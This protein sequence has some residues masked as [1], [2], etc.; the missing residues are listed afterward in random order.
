MVV[1]LE[2]KPL[3]QGIDNGSAVVGA[4]VLVG[5][6]VFERIGLGEEA[7]HVV[8]LELPDVTTRI[9][10]LQELAHHVV[11]QELGSVLLRVGDGVEV[12]ALVIGEPGGG[13]LRVL[14]AL[15]GGREEL[16]ELIVSEDRGALHVRAQRFH[17][18]E[19][20]PLAVIL[21]GGHGAPEV[22]DAAHLVEPAVVLER[23][24]G[25]V[26]VDNA[27][28]VVP[29][30][31]ILAGDVSLLVRDDLVA[32][33]LDNLLDRAAVDVYS[34]GLPFPVVPDLLDLARRGPDS[35]V[36]LCPG[37]IVVVLEE[38]TL[39]ETV[40]HRGDTAVLVVRNDGGAAAG[41]HA[42]DDPALAVVLVGG[43]LVQHVRHLGE[44]AA[45]IGVFDRAAHAITD[46]GK[47]ALGVVLEP[48]DLRVV[49]VAEARGPASLFV[50]DLA[51]HAGRGPERQEEALGVILLPVASLVGP[52]VTCLGFEDPEG[53]VAVNRRVARRLLVRDAA[54][55][56][57]GHLAGEG[58]GQELQVVARVLPV[59][60]VGVKAPQDLDVSAR[61]LEQH[62]G[63]LVCVLP[64]DRVDGAAHHVENAGKLVV[65]V[66]QVKEDLSP[67]R[68]GIR[69][70]LHAI[71]LLGSRCD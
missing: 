13:G 50:E 57:R 48:D 69:E 43:F 5:G 65:G 16:A 37:L 11:L 22:N 4:V 40:H 33:V 51:D 47:P 60:L 41:I 58:I 52:A 7:A 63:S 46:P 61:H 67:E 36:G 39:A 54:P 14:I 42:P 23:H 10:H 62:V 20:I 64:R 26:G 44:K 28:Q 21:K 24:L 27:G 30:V 9:L 29:L 38:V 35:G 66:A 18:L 32:A 53:V 49:A 68:G 8:V 2:V 45:G 6:R 19:E 17:L 31:V 3:E 34:L 71:H 59:P 1:V 12:A 70:A 55:I 25:T 56:D 15:D